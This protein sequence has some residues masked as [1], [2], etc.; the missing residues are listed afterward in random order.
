MRMTGQDAMVASGWRACRKNNCKHEKTGRQ[1]AHSITPA[2]STAWAPHFR[3]KIPFAP[4]RHRRPSGATTLE[5]DVRLER[6]ADDIPH[7]GCQFRSGGPLAARGDTPIQPDDYKRASVKRAKRWGNCAT[8]T[9]QRSLEL[10]KRPMPTEVV[11]PASKPARLRDWRLLKAPLPHPSRQAVS[12]ILNR[13]ISPPR[14]IDRQER[15]IRIGMLLM[16]QIEC[17]IVN[18]LR[19]PHP[20]FVGRAFR[21]DPIL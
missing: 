9:S 14:R 19:L 1:R 3:G 2:H 5:C 15:P 11:D 18:Q 4:L 10:S 12:R 20:G 21:T 16:D 6:F 8:G 7:C 13:I 17:C